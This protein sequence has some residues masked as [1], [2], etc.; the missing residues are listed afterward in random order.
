MTK[1]RRISVTGG[2]GFIG[3]HLTDN[4]LKSGHRV[5]VIDNLNS[6]HVSNLTELNENPNLKLHRVDISC[7]ED[8]DGIF[9]GV[10]YVFHLAGM[11][12]I[13][14]SI[15]NPQKYFKTNVEGTLNVLRSAHKSGVSKLVYAASSSC[16]G[17]PDTFPTSE[18]CD[19][20]P[21]YPYALLGTPAANQNG[22]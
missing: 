9:E 16:Y 20:K 18:T 4:L 12:D 8:M 15:E 22:I 2:A 10:D 6:G 21:M 1:M 7:W 13:V 3:S 19:I 17:L 5:D 11:A 14:P